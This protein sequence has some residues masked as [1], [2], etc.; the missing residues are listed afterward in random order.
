[1]KG[2]RKAL[3]WGL[4]LI[5]VGVIL[6]GKAVGLFD[7]DIFFDGWWTLFLIVP[8]FISLFTE[9]RKELAGNIIGLAIGVSLLLACQGVFGFDMIWKILVPVVIILI[10]CS[11]IF[12]GAGQKDVSEKIHKLNEGADEKDELVAAFSG[13]KAKVEKEFKSKSVCAAFGGIDLDLSK[14]GIKKEAVVNAKAFFGG[15]TI[16]VPDGVKVETCSSSLF[17]GVSDKRKNTEVKDG[18]PTLYVNANCM[19]GGVE[20]K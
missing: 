2:S 19:F 7:W 1:M 11:L 6:G 10:G 17:G 18:A 8:C 14:A 16:I 12:K 3:I 9:G 4:V 15:V 20:I 5:A 13:Q